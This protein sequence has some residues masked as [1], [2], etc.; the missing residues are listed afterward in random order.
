MQ[1]AFEILIA[2]HRDMML[3]YASTLVAG[4]AHQAEDI[5]Q[6]ACI[7]AYKNLEK[8]D[9]NRSFPKWIRGFVRYKALDS[10]RAAY[11][12]PMIEDP[13]VIQ[14]MEDVFSM[15]D[16]PKEDE[17]WKERL[18]L[19]RACTN[20]LNPGMREV[21]VLYYQIELSLKGIAEK[22][23]INLATAGQRLSRARKLLRNCISSSIA[24][25]ATN[26]QS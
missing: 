14:G 10:K 20:K 5:V 11:R 24:I 26:E 19:L 25:S 21:V 23:A 22:L 8:Y 4:D 13:D 15:F 7:A 3:S 18:S 1:K 16:Q 9:I 17:S 6:E 12:R 2:E